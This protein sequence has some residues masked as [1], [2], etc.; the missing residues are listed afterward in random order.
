MNDVESAV[1][2]DVLVKF[3]LRILIIFAVIFLL[4][5][6]TPQL[7]KLVDGWIKKYRKNHT[8]ETNYGIRSIYELPPAPE[9]DEEYDLGA[10]YDESDEEDYSLDDEETAETAPVQEAQTEEIH[11][12][13]YAKIDE[14]PYDLSRRAVKYGWKFAPDIEPMDLSKVVFGMKNRPA[15]Y[16]PVPKPNDEDDE[17]DAAQPPVQY[18]PFEE[19]FFDDE[20]EIPAQTAAEDEE[21]PWFMR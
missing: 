14:E 18:A 11:L 19:H 2:L 20:P 17:F 7:A 3:S 10:E 16:E 21:L 8:K 1:D 15:T 4:A 9:D 5:V 12:F 6:L 13:S